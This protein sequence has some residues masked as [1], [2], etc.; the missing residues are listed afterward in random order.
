MTI[1]QK[2]LLMIVAAL[3]CS[4]ALAQA[5]RPDLQG[6]WTNASLTSL[7]RPQGVE[8]LIVTP[9]RARAIAAATPIATLEGGLDEGDGVNNTPEA[10]ADDFGTRAYNNFWV[11][12][13]S[14]LALIKG[15]FRTSYIVDP[16]SGRIP[17]RED[18][19]YAVS[20]THLT[21]PTKRIV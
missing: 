1:L 10:G 2:P 9:E 13:G 8:S 19:Q 17:R 6:I 12:P 4:F 14:N 20:Y 21:L 11:S 5:D 3:A 7:Q 18:P 15:E 16:P